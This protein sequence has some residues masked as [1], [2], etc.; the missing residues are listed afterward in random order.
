MMNMFLKL[1]KKGTTIVI[2]SHRQDPLMDYAK[3]IRMERGGITG[4][5]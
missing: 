1:N 3:V 4:S 5:P 2:A